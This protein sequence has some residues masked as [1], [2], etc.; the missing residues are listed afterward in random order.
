MNPY[1]D[2]LWHYLLRWLFAAVGVALAGGVILFVVILLWWIF[3]PL[4][5][6]FA[7]IALIGIAL[8]E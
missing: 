1:L 8:K 5:L 7:G 4:F 6:F 3:L 2:L